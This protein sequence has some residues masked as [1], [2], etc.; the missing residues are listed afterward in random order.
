MYLVIIHVSNN[1]IYM[2]LLIIHVLCNVFP[3]MDQC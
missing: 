3:E 1:N 2:S